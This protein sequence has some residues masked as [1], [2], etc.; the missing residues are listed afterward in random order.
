MVQSDIG[1]VQ[2][3]ADRAEYLSLYRQLGRGWRTGANYR[4]C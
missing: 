2:R 1:A 3:A 4:I